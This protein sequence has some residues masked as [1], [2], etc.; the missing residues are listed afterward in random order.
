[1]ADKVKAEHLGDGLYAEFDGY[2]IVLKANGRTNPTD[3]I[4]V[5]FETFEALMKYAK[6]VWSDEN[7]YNLEA[8]GGDT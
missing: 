5:N 6:K 8:N 4:Y 1:M 7:E 3:T 2:Q